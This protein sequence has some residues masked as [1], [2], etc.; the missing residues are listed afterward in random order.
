M[1][2]NRIV[3]SEIYANKNMKIVNNK[4]ICQIE[5]TYPNVLLINSLLKTKIIQGGT[6]TKDYKLIK[7]K[8]YSVT[9]LNQF[10]MVQKSV[11]KTTK[12]SVNI[13]GQLCYYLS[14]QL[15]YLESN[16]F[17]TFI[18][19][20]PEYV[21]VINEQIFIY[22]GCDLL[23]KIN[24]DETIMVSSP[25]K[26][27]DFFVSPE[28]LNVR[29]I[30]SYIHFKSVYFSF[31]MLLLQCLIS[32]EEDIYLNYLDYYDFEYLSN[33]KNEKKSVEE[34]KNMGSSIMEEYLDSL[35]IKDTKLYWLLSRCF[36]KDPN[37]RSILFI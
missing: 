26:N 18:G 36:L 16:E 10:I 33:E 35:S 29:E 37:Y 14:R 23:S 4:N 22:L 34:R 25:F 3:M 31:A 28:L 15:H 2:S 6:S 1:N 32:L 9:T 20:N 5:F 12:L 27:T 21:I 19:Y 7:F 13:V 24:E 11:T 8:V 30:P 17:V